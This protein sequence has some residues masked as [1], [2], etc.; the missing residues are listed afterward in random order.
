MTRDPEA[1]IRRRWDLLVV[2]G[3]IHGLFAAY[4]A[5][6]RGLA[7]ALVDAADFGSGL[8]FNHQRT[9]HG[10]LRALQGGD[11][12]RTRQQIRERRTWARLAPHLVRPLPFLVGTYRGLRRPRSALRL[13]FAVYDWLGRARN[14]RVS[15]ELHLPKTRLESAATTRRLFP[16]IAEVGLS[17]GAIWYDYQTRHPDRLTW[18]VAAAAERAGATLVSYARVVGPVHA[19]GRIA[20]ARVQDAVDG[21]ERDVDATVTLL[22]AGSGAGT[23]AAAVRRGRR[24]AAHPGPQSPPRSPG[25]GHR[26]GRAGPVRPDA[27]RRALGR[28]RARRHGA[29]GHGRS[30]GRGRA[31]GWQRRGL[32]RQRERGVSESSRRRAGHPSRPPRP[33]AGRPPRWARGT[34]RRS[35]RSSGMARAASRASCR[36]SA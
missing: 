3:G 33:H 10:G 8:S 6:Q 19:N 15:V 31:S 24:S 7:V 27:D 28:R 5:A 35:S 34:A 1:L 22:A 20:G 11:V 16:G 13:G 26:A 29:I 36:S 9:L 21:R 17:G 14:E 23:P 30:R 12:R 4:D 32:P 2:G 25:E 18:L